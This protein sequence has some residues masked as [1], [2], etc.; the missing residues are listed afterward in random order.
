M[1]LTKYILFSA[2]KQQ[3]YKGQ[4]ETLLDVFILLGLKLSVW[5]GYLFTPVGI[6]IIMVLGFDPQFYIVEYIRTTFPLIAFLVRAATFNNAL[7]LQFC[8]VVGRFW[9]MMVALYE[10]NV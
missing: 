10:A 2:T 1:L 6:V 5:V 4:N 3:N 9:I 8:L 7:L